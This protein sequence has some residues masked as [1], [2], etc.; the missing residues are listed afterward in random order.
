MER[1]IYVHGGPG[2]ASPTRSNNLRR[3]QQRN[4]LRVRISIFQV[5]YT[6]HWA[7]GARATLAPPDEIRLKKQARVD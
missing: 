3:F 7:D 4:T 2:G 5:Q 6:L 1:T